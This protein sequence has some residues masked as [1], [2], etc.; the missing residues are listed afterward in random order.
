MGRNLKYLG[1]VLLAATAWLLIAL[2][3][4]WVENA[5]VEKAIPIL[6]GAGVISIVLGILLALA[7]PVGRK[8]SRGRCARCG[9]PIE[10]GQSYCLDH[11]REAVNEYQDHARRADAYRPGRRS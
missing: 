8:L 5:L 1:L 3:A 11:M 4:D 10:R 9:A 2:E 6:A 7:S